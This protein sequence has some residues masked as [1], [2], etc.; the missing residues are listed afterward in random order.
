[1]TFTLQELKTMIIPILET[2]PKGDEYRVADAIVEIIRQD[3]EVREAVG[4][5]R[6]HQD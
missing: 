5:T 6:Q 1:M 4:E 2:M 3:R